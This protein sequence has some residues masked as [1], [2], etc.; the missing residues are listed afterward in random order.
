VTRIYFRLCEMTPFFV[1]NYFNWEVGFFVFQRKSFNGKMFLFCFHTKV[2]KLK[3]TNKK[4]MIISSNIYFVSFGR[5]FN[6]KNV[7]RVIHERGISFCRNPLYTLQQYLDF[8][9]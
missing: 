6:L 8:K 9:F 5:F 7:Y 4:E 2:C 3:R 1:I